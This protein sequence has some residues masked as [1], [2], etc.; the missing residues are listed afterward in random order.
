MNCLWLRNPE[1][2]S[3]LTSSLL[4]ELFLQPSKMLTN[5]APTCPG[6]EYYIKGQQH[7][8]SVENLTIGVLRM[9][10]L[11]NLYSRVCQNAGWLNTWPW[12]QF[13]GCWPVW[14]RQWSRKPRKTK[15][16]SDAP[17]VVRASTISQISFSVCVS[18][19]MYVCVPRVT[20]PGVF[21]P[22]GCGM[23]GSWGCGN[24]RHVQTLSG[25]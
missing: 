4:R 17:C 2:N 1:L 21:L 14:L 23:K 22:V 18:T 25:H 15:Q 5:K 3:R 12:N 9:S 7:I 13:R 16:Q 20:M 11:R 8:T 6:V 10:G 24:S 19:G